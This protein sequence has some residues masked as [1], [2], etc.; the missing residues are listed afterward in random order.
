MKVVHVNE[1]SPDRELSRIEVPELLCGERDVI[2][3]V[4][5]AGVNRADLMQRA[6]RY[7][8]PAGASKVLGLEVAG[9]IKELGSAVSRWSIGERVCALLVGGGYAESVIVPAEHIMRLPVVTPDLLRKSTPEGV[10]EL[11]FI[12]GA[13]L[14][15]AFITAFVNLFC[16]GELRAGERVLIHGGSSGVGTAAIQ[17]A[18]LRGALVAVTVGNNEKAKRCLEIGADLAIDYK[19]EDFTE[20]LKGWA[21]QGVDLILD[22]IGGEYLA[23]NLSSLAHR[24][25]LVIIASMGGTTGSLDIPTL[26]RKRARIIGSVLRSRSDQEK[27]D[28]ISQFSEQFLPAF[29][30][31]ALKVIVDSTFDIREAHKAHLRMTSSEH[32]GK[33]VL[34]VR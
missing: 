16:E 5:A 23:R 30:T 15:E 18:K 2:I 28:L 9:V 34:K 21:P 14:P 12:E 7:P 10:T 20:A 32:I 27:A 6:G 22:C 11:S 26:M 19:R 33:I 4:H 3:E 31:G 24:G 1:G 8:A 13:G 25:R 29:S 17:L